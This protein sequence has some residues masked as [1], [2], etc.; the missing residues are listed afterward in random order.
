MA[1]SPVASFN[2]RPGQ[3]QRQIATRLRRERR[4]RIASRAAQQ[5]H[6]ENLLVLP[7]FSKDWGLVQRAIAGDTNSQESLFAPY[8]SR[9][10]RI[11]FAVLRN[12]E[13]A[14]D[15]VQ[16]GL[17]K[18]F[19]SLRSFQGRSSLSTWL[20][21]IVKNAALMALRRK[22]SRPE[23]SLDELLEAQSEVLTHTAVDARPNPEQICAATEIRALVDK[24]LRQ[25][26]PAL[27]IALRLRITKAHST[28]ELG[29]SLGISAAAFKSRIS[30]A[31]RQIAFEMRR[32]LVSATA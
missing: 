12:K 15:A 28:A 25:L 6:G 24:E 17:C 32:S 13:D 3:A 4:D 18:A 16:D 11:A 10:H 30:R 31:R 26:S 7:E 21:S 2:V 8:T 27:Q 1:T 9:L 22:K 5:E 20:T 14:E 19:A 23:A 29:N